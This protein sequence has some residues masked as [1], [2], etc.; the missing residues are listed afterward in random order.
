[1]SNCKVCGSE[2]VKSLS[3]AQQIRYK[4]C[5]LE[6]ELAYSVCEGC[7]REFVAT[8]QIRKNDQAILAAK[9]HAGGLLSP[10][11]VHQMREALGL[12][13]YKAAELF[14]ASGITE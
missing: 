8:G 1:M 13:Q 4:S 7:G 11:E 3:E 12:T 10:E 9:R 5:Q 6:V 2:R 14:G